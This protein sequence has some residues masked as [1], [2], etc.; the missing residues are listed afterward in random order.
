MTAVT[1][2]TGSLLDQKPRVA[3]PLDTD[4]RPAAL[5]E[6]AYLTHVRNSGSEAV[7]EVALERHSGQ[8]ARARTE[9]S[10][11]ADDAAVTQR[12]VERW[13]KF[14]LWQ[15]GGWRVFAAGPNSVIHSLM[16][17]YA[18]GGLRQFDA[19]FMSSVYRA[20]FEIVA[21]DREQLP[22]ASRATCRAS[23]SLSGCRIGFDAGGS[24]R[25]VAAL[26]DGVQVFASE[27][28]WHP[29][30]QS[31]P[32]YHF[33][34]IMHS[35]AQARAHLPRLDALGVSSAG[36]YIDNETRVASL[37]RQVP[38]ELFDKHI[39]R[40][41]LD[42]G[43]A[44]GVP[45]EVANDGDVAALAGA[46]ALDDQPVLGLALGTSLAAGYIDAEGSIA[47]GL[48]ELAFAPLDYADHAPI[49]EWSGDQGV[50]VSYL[51]QDAA[52][53]LAAPAGIELPPD[54]SPARKLTELQRHFAAGHLG[55]RAVFETL[56]VYL[57][58][59]LLGM[60]SY[61][62]LKHVLLMGRV[63][64]G[65]SGDLM[66][67]MAERVLLEEAPELATRLH[68]RLPDEFTR[69]VGQSVAAASL[70]QL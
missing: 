39:R 64:S 63:L 15:H 46:M 19:E 8:V 30:L 7:L 70:V 23:R 40:I 1:A 18:P 4:F 21:V 13:L 14:L 69:R 35:I 43:A 66:L 47:G 57:G 6:R 59:A 17:A 12:Y 49:D 10:T 28:V 56:G 36:I 16:G 41:Y 65:T 33:D 55:A 50:G 68:L 32:R 34:G 31:D 2:L 60:A 20:P 37:F 52:I 51:S 29:K 53:R 27:E 48:N 44:L 11:L 26:I 25:K 42:V 24:D 38:P 54:L 62:P 5:A 3:P 61:Y 9:I 58:Y 22:E 45:V 67:S